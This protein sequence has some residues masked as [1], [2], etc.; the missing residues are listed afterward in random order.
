M[1]KTPTQEIS[2][3]AKH[4]VV[5]LSELRKKNMHLYK[6]YRSNEKSIET[7]L[8][9]VYNIDVLD[10]YNSMKDKLQIV[11][12]IKYHFGNEVNLSKLR[13]EHRTIYNY[14][15]KLHGKPVDFLTYYCFKIVYDTKV[16]DSAL[17]YILKDYVS[18]GFVDFIS[19]PKDIYNKVYYRSKLLNMGMYEY[20]KKV[21]N[22][23]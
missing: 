1:R 20:V 3:Y 9:E 4:N 2:E 10:D 14:I 16:V 18:D 6:F 19:M 23:D 7:A 17:K 22:M 11:K 21:V 15:V 5:L 8:L 12:Y 13:K